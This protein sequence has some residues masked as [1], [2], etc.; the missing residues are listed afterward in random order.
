MRK[1]S[2]KKMISICCAAA[3]LVLSLGLGGWTMKEVKAY[4][5]IE[6]ENPV[7]KRA[8]DPWVVRHEDNLYYCWAGSGINVRKIENLSDMTYYNGVKVWEAPMG[9]MYSQQIW[10]PELHYIDGEWYIY[11]AA[12]NGVNSAHRMYVLKGTSQD[13]TDPF[14]FVGQITDPSDHWAI[15]GTVMQY[16]GEMY[17]IW[18]GW[19]GDVDEGQQTYIA[20]MSDPVTIDSERVM[21]SSPSYDWEQVGLPIQEGQVAL[22]DDE[23][24]TAIIIYSASGSWT[25]DYCLG[26]LT[27]TGTDPMDPESWTKSEEPV[28]SKEEGTYGPGHCSFVE[29]YDGQLWMVYHANTESGTGWDGRSCRVQ[30]VSWDGTTLDLGT[31][32]G[33]GETMQLAVLPTEESA[34]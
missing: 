10:A 28:F 34:E 5:Y 22:T 6:I 12:C 4:E 15:D 25:D 26:Q 30:P 23:S 14:E 18:S 29:N 33:A 31:P 9:K 8:N 21:I 2:R 7:Y 32:I 11:F 27:L 3:M 20:H 13:P 16:Q 17:F 19:E 1:N 24:G